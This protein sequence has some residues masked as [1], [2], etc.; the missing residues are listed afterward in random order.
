MPLLTAD[1]S[2]PTLL[3]CRIS[4]R[5]NKIERKTGQSETKEPNDAW[6]AETAATCVVI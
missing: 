1:R 2:R 6:M 5:S 4:R 3:S